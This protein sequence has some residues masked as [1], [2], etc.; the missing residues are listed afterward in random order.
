MVFLFAA[1]EFLA[2]P[3]E[4]FW[5]C[6]IYFYCGASIFLLGNFFAERKQINLRF[7]GVLITLIMALML[8]FFLDPHET[9]ILSAGALLV[10]AVFYLDKNEVFSN[11]LAKLRILGDLTYSTYLWH[12]PL[13]IFIILL[14]EITGI[15]RLIFSSKYF[16]VCYF[17]MLYAISF[18]SF[19]CL[20]RPLRYSIKNVFGG[21]KEAI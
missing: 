11:R 4:A 3:G 14:V 13:Q 16:F 9:R 5:R 12:V 20:E 1:L 8:N 6:G 10:I 2:F 17:I 19:T 15:D 18:I 7:E 21:N